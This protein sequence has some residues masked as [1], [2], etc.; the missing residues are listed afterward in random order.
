[1]KASK[2]V[3]FNFKTTQEEAKDICKCIAS[4]PHASWNTWHDF[5]SALKEAGIEC[6]EAP[7]SS[8]LE[9][10]TIKAKITNKGNVKFNLTEKETVQILK[11]LNYGA[12]AELWC[13]F[14]QACVSVGIVNEDTPIFPI[15]GGI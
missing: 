11:A 9:N 6:Y 2:E 1:M 12:P 5:G 8:K 10:S 13:A 15:K 4:S 3:S 7:S 14:G